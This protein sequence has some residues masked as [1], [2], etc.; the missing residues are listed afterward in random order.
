MAGP[1]GTAEVSVTTVGFTDLALGTL[2][3]AVVGLDFVVVFDDLAVLDAAVL[4]LAVLRAVLVAVSDSVVFSTVVAVKFVV[5]IS[6][7]FLFRCLFGNRI[8]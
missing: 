1:S 5:L 2:P 3:E 7:L 6:G 8:A 4:G